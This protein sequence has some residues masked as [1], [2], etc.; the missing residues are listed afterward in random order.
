[1]FSY[2]DYF[3]LT[4]ASFLN[5]ISNVFFLFFMPVAKITSAFFF[6]I[7][8]SLIIELLSQKI[9][10]NEKQIRL[11]LIMVGAFVIFASMLLINFRINSSYV[12][13]LQEKY[14]TYSP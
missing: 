2:S 8:V 1:M 13:F 5:P 12:F 6:I 11:K 3:K 14:I 7:F 4:V 9:D 10:T